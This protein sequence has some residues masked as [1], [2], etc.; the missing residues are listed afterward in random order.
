MKYSRYYADDGG[1]THIED[2]Q[3]ELTPRDFA[4]P[5]PPLYLSPLTPATGFAFARFPAGW[6]G[7]W[8]PT[9][10]RQIYFILAG[11]I[12]G[13]TSDGDR[14]RLGPGDAVLLEDTTGKGHRA[15]VVS[16]GDV[17]TAVVQLAD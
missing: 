10:R 13:D 15:R 4:P 6:G 1:E 9:P 5:A 16:D 2:V 14:R 7:D 8:H 17:L 3:V 12:E 11:E